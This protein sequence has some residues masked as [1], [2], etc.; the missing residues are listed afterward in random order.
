MLEVDP[1]EG[2]NPVGAVSPKVLYWSTAFERHMFT[3]SGKI[4]L[5]MTSVGTCMS[6][7]H[8]RKYISMWKLEHEHSDWASEFQVSINTILLCAAAFFLNSPLKWIRM[9]SANQQH[10][11]C[12]VV[13][14][15]QMWSDSTGHAAERSFC[16][17]PPGRSTFKQQI[18]QNFFS[19]GRDPWG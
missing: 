2:V 8:M 5:N 7:S 19:W 10:K 3:C 4:Q 1:A 15:F 18:F 12:A 13:A 17:L 9:F 11:K 14:F 6:Q 16:F